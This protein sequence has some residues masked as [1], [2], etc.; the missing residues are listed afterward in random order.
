MQSLHRAFRMLRTAGSHAR[1]TVTGS[2]LM[3]WTMLERTRRTSKRS[4]SFGAPGPA[5]E[6]HLLEGVD[7]RLPA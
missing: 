7:R 2:S 3:P 1:T 6:V 5:D 4:G